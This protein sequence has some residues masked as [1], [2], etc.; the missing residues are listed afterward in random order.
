MT[1][2]NASMLRLPSRHSGRTGYWLWLR[3][4]LVVVAAAHAGWGQLPARTPTIWRRGWLQVPAWFGRRLQLGS[5]MP[6]PAR[7]ELDES[8]AGGSRPSATRRPEPAD[9]WVRSAHAPTAGALPVHLASVVALAP[10]AMQTKPATDIPSHGRIL[11]RPCSHHKAVSFLR[12]RRPLHRRLG[13]TAR[14]NRAT[15]SG[16]GRS[17]PS[18]LVGV[19]R[20]TRR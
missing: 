9:I 16:L 19:A 5:G 15:R 13:R 12:R 11:R 6:A 17:H 4:L 8:T 10:I 3:I 1:E 7:T 20:A 18:R 14:A 2:R